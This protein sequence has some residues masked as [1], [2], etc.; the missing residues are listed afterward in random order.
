[1]KRDFN[2][3]PFFVCL[4]LTHSFSS[5][6]KA[7]VKIEPPLSPSILVGTPISTSAIKL[8]WKDNSTTEAGFKIER[9]LSTGVYTVI[10]QTSENITTYTDTGLT[11]GTQYSYRVFAFNNG[12]NSPTYTN[13]VTLEPLP[14][15]NS[16]AGNTV[17]SASE[18]TMVVN[19]ITSN[20]LPAVELNNSGLYYHIEISGN[21]KKPTQCNSIAVKYIAKLINGTIIDQT[22]GTSTTTFPMSSILEGLR[23]GYP[24]IG[25]GG[26]IKLYIPPSLAYGSTGAYN[27]NT[28]QY[29][30]PPNSVLIFETELVSVL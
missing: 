8:E 10:G 15:C 24:L 28:G 5:C 13:E 30:V 1:M 12:G 14:L 20:G 25:E 22:T 7:N 27:P 18:K 3:L 19:Y 4:L 26:K 9:K 6:Q 11:T 21:T 2:L 29:I 17:A 16:F 23:R